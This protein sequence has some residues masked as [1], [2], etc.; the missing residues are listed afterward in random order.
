MNILEV[1]K[2]LQERED[3]LTA[4]YHWK[5]EN[6]VRM[7]DL[8]STEGKVAFVARELADAALYYAQGRMPTGS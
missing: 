7:L 2:K 5:A 4:Q 3:A 1:S 6:I 8:L